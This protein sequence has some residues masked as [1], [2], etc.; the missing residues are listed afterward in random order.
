MDILPTTVDLAAIDLDTPIE[1]A[2][3]TG[4]PAPTAMA[5]LLD[6]DSEGVARH[7][8]ADLGFIEMHV[9]HGDIDTAIEELARRGW[10]RF[11][12]VDITGIAD[13]L[14]RIN[15]L[16]EISD[17][18]TEVIVVG[19]Q[20]DIVLYRDLKTAGV[21]EYFYKPLIGSLL[22]RALVGISS[23][24]ETARPTRSGRLVFVLG[25]RG[26]VGATTIATNLA[27]HF[28]EVQQRRVLLLDLDL[29]NGDAA[30][31]LDAQPGHGL[32]EALDDPRRIDDLFLER[33]VVSVTHRLG[34]LAGLE[35]LSDHVAANEEAILQLL[36]KVLTHFRYVLIDLPGEIALSLPTLLHMPSTLLLV[37]DGS[38]AATR[39]VGRW[40][41]FI[42]PN[43]PERTLLHVLNKKN[44]DG[45]LP[46]EEMLRVIPPP[47]VSIHWS[48]EIMG[49]A[50]FGTKAVQKCAAIRSG[51]AGVS[52]QLSG[53]AAE[54]QNRPFWKRILSSW[55]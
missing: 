17:P 30:L 16:A 22:N 50:A 54:T 55:A 48:R 43:T 6:A 31:Q 7:S 29:H 40:Q 28:A 46:V 9:R 13:P 49:A 36:Q 44:A 21:A 35:P 3:P 4:A 42:G 15:R 33:G 8:F 25:V 38:I 45:A 39:E 19:E 53:T 23:G 14:P 2:P 32:R 51:M 26:G 20:N 5:Y 34:L 10:P 37:S 27:W 41:E 24:T 52:R 18:E 47:G 12:I 1:N 11:L